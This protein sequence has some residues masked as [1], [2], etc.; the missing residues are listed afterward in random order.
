MALRS[1]EKWC[2]TRSDNAPSITPLYEFRENRLAICLLAIGAFLLGALLGWAALLQLRNPFVLSFVAIGCILLGVCVILPQERR[3]RFLAQPQQWNPAAAILLVILG[4]GVQ[5]YS[6]Y[7]DSFDAIGQVLII[8]GSIL[9]GFFILW[10]RPLSYSLILDHTSDHGNISLREPGEA[11]GF[12]IVEQ[13]QV[14]SPEGVLCACCGYCLNGL[15]QESRCPECGFDQIPDAPYVRPPFARLAR[16]CL[17]IV[18]VCSPMVFLLMILVKETRWPVWAV[19]MGASLFVA[20]I[21][22]RYARCKWALT[23][24]GLVCVCGARQSSGIPLMHL[25]VAEMKGRAIRVFVR[26]DCDRGFIV[27]IPCGDRHAG[28]RLVMVLNESAR[29]RICSGIRPNYYD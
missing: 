24:R 10:Q 26:T 18:C 6:R 5:L 23:Q 27:I 8:L 21:Y 11:D 28:E 7:G 29:G 14:S 22:L 13:S 9:M 12:R 3:P 1:E 19:A 17:W 15:I 2:C 16:I 25:R 20:V 4:G